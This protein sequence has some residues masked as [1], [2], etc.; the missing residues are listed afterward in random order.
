MQDILR[1]SSGEE[2]FI[3]EWDRMQL[4]TPTRA[5]VLQAII[6]LTLKNK[7]APTLLQTLKAVQKLQTAQN[8]P[9]L[10]DNS[11]MTVYHHI[12]NLIQAGYL[13][14]ETRWPL[15]LDVTVKA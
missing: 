9:N 7:N 6:E 14:E 12:S 13:A 4:R 11:H 10:T 2:I 8:V 5:L 3:K 15:C 1:L